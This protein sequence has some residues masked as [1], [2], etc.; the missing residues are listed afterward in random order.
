MG[1]GA[2]L[3]A[4]E[5]SGVKYVEHCAIAEKKGQ[6]FRLVLLR[7]IDPK[8]LRLLKNHPL[9]MRSNSAVSTQ[10]AGSRCDAYVCC[11][12][13][14]PEPDLALFGVCVI[15]S[16]ETLTSEFI[17]AGE[18]KKKLN[19]VPLETLKQNFTI[20]KKSRAAAPLESA[21]SL[22]FSGNYPGFP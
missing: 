11:G 18:L 22:N 2:L 14:F 1:G 3:R 10:D 5:D 6:A 19:F 13:N 15:H 16:V 8:L 4:D 17:V 20:S 7:G 12:C 21:N 9:Y